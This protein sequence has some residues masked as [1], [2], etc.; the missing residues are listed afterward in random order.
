[1]RYIKKPYR[2]SKCF[3]PLHM[4]RTIRFKVV[5]KSQ[6]VRQSSEDFLRNKP[7]LCVDCAEEFQIQLQNF[8]RSFMD[9]NRRTE[10]ED[11]GDDTELSVPLHS[12]EGQGVDDKTDNSEHDQRDNKPSGE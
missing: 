11:R 2:C 3:K 1:M 5:Y 12:G 9:G 7:E 10:A 6:G 4:K 8:V